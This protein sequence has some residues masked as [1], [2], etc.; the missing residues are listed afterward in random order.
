MKKRVSIILVCA[1]AIIMLAACADE[2]TTVADPTPAPAAEATPAPAADPTP[3]PEAPPAEETNPSDES[4]FDFDRPIAVFTR[5]D[6]S[7]TRDAFVD[8]TGVGDDM[9]VEA[10][11][12][13]STGAIRT[14]VAEN[15]LAISYVS[16]GSLN[17]EVRAIAIDGVYPSH[18]TVRDG[19]FPLSR[20]FLLAFTEESFADPLVQ[21]FLDFVLSVEG[22]ELLAGSWTPAVAN[23]V[24]FTPSDL[25][26]S[27]TISGSTSVAPAM[28]LLA[29]AYMALNENV[30]IDVMSTGTGTGLEQA[31][32]GVADIGMA[33]R[34]LREGE[35]ENLDY[36][37]ML[38]DGVAVIVNVENPLQGLTMDQVREIF[39]TGTLR[40]SD[41]VS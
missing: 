31:A 34:E 26:G 35:L 33:S 19:S 16:V 7:G 30:Q 18:D 38:L 29:E 8:A 40:W 36:I 22:Q 10:G 14:A 28:D 39:V 20:R 17:D 15:E 25:S 2:G 12:L 37:A 24:A 9:S 21:D 3:T 13:T 23:P 27:L 1:F 4:D 32:T 5:E 11:V 6:G 41:V